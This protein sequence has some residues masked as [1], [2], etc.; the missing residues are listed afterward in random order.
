MSFGEYINVIQGTAHCYTGTNGTSF[1]G[2]MGL[3]Q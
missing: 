2:V 3:S 1:K